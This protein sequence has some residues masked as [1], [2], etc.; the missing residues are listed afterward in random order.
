ML[1]AVIIWCGQ[2]LVRAVRPVCVE[3]KYKFEG[4]CRSTEQC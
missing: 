4:F 1:M 3:P 2:Y